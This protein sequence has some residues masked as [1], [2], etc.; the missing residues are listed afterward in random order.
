MHWLIVVLFATPA[1][2]IYIFTDPKFDT[3]LE[4][5]QSIR[6]PKKVPGYTQK[7]FEEYQRVLPIGAIGCLQEDEIKRILEESQA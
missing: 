3:K 5:E 2:D 6:D 1:G 7:L 4:C